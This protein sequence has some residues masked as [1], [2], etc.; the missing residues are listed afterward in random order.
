[1]DCDSVFT[2]KDGSY[3]KSDVGCLRFF[4]ERQTL[5]L[6][7][8]A[9]PSDASER[10]VTAT[11]RAAF[12][13]DCNDAAE[14]DAAIVAE[15]HPRPMFAMRAALLARPVSASPSTASDHKH[16]EPHDIEHR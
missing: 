3:K 10:S 16:H 7:E 4:L 6:V 2:P 12:F 15:S 1:V 14:F 11:Q 13:D 8:H 5:S 9:T